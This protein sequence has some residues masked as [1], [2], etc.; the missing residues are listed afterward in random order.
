MNTKLNVVSIV[1][2]IFLITTAFSPRST[3][4][5]VLNR[6]QSERTYQ[7][8]PLLPVTR[9]QDSGNDEDLVVHPLKQF[10]SACSSENSQRQNLCVELEPN[11]VPGSIYLSGNR[12]TDNQVYPSQ[13]LHS[14][15]V[16][17]NIQRQESCVE[18]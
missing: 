11:F 2:A 12:N 17:E 14:A 15:C 9:G 18:Q 16:S 8:V 5:Q 4:L 3:P 6:A 7:I 10:H 13:K 1:V